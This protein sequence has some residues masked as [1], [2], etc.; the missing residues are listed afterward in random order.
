MSDMIGY[1]PETGHSAFAPQNRHQASTQNQRSSRIC[2]Q[3]TSPAFRPPIAQ[4]QA[5]TF[6]GL[7]LEKIRIWSTKS[8]YDFAGNG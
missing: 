8:M 3:A 6:I 4:K 7:L 5:T 1:P 2:L